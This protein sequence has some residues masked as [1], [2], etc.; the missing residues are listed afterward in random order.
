M[1]VI[2]IPT[3][4]YDSAETECVLPNWMIMNTTIKAKRNALPM[5]ASGPPIIEN[6]SMMAT[7]APSAAPDATP[8]VNG[9]TSGLPKHP[10][11]KA[12][13]VASATPP[14]MAMR[15][16]GNRILQM[17]LCSVLVGVSKPKIIFAVV[18][19]SSFS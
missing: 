18:Q 11:I 14:T 4:M 19:I 17:M 16:R 10:C 7:A 1:K 2:A 12:P 15:I 8:S 6:P 3:R 13:A 5:I 9:E